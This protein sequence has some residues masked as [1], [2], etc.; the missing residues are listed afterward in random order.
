MA[1]WESPKI[2]I[3]NLG[4]SMC[5]MNRPCDKGVGDIVLT[6]MVIGSRIGSSGGKKRTLGLGFF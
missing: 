4:L 2:E 5:G 6:A 3:V 1:G